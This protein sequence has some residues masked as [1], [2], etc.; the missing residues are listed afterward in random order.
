MAN[1]YVSASL[2]PEKTNLEFDLCIICQK[3]EKESLVC[4]SSIDSY[5][6]VLDFVKEWAS[7]GHKQYSEAWVKLQ[8]ISVKDLEEKS[9]SWH[10]SC[11]KSVAHTGM[12]KERRRGM[13][14][15]YLA[16]TNP[17]VSLDRELIILLQS[18]LS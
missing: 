6:K 15:S 9:S 11:Y 14:E 10:R 12:I 16:Q 13:K 17:G 7:Y 8:D 1:L 4:K 2:D 5:R 3:R 18:V